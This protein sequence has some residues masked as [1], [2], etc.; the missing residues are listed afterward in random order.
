MKIK[1]LSKDERKIRFILEDS[2]PQFA[3]ALR[4]IMMSEVPV[5]AVDTV[6]FYNNDSALYDEVISHR[7]GMVPL[8]FDAKTFKTPDDCDCEGKGCSNCQIVFVVDKKGPA[9]VLSKDMKSADAAVAKPLVDDMPIAELFEGQRLKAEA[10]AK[11]GFGKEHAKWQASRVWYGYLPIV[12]QKEKVTNGHDV[13]KACAHGAVKVVD[14]KV[15]VSPDC[16]LSCHADRA[17]KPEGAFVLKGDDTKFVFT[18]ESIS[19]LTAEDIIL[20]AADI[21]RDKAKEFGKEVEGLK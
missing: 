18:V 17:A 14:G 1:I 19:G 21:L 7:F 8:W 4:R 3:N 11:L 16:D 15:E 20:K 10:T 9:T 12:E 5:L 2:T 6:C 13:E